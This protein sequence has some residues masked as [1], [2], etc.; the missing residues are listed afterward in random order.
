MS[1]CKPYSMPVDTWAKLSDDNEPPV[2]DMTAYRS[3]TGALQYITFSRPH[4]AYAIQQVYLHLPTPRVGMKTGQENHV[5]IDFVYCV[6][7]LYIV[8]QE[9]TGNRKNSRNFSRN[10]IRDGCFPTVL[11]ITVWS[12]FR[13]GKF[14]MGFLFFTAHISV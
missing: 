4:I 10:G 8:F 9:Y 12:Y 13:P 3:L 14:P 6:N 2:S 5:P 7:R 11:M 1:D